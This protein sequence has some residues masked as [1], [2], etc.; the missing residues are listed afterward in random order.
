MRFL[1]EILERPKH[2]KPY[3]MLVVGY[4]RDGAEVPR[5]GK[6]PIAEITRFWD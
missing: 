4:P 6:K 1:N 3:L 5:I 2:E